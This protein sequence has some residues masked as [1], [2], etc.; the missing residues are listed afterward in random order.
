MHGKQAAPDEASTAI[1]GQPRFV[2]SAAS[3]PIFLPLIVTGPSRILSIERHEHMIRGLKDK[4]VWFSSR[5]NQL[6]TSPVDVPASQLR[7]GDLFVHVA[8]GNRKQ[9]WLWNA[10]RWNPI[11]LHDPHPYLRGYVLNILANGEPSWVT[12]DTI[13]T[14]IS[15]IKKRE[16]ERQRSGKSVAAD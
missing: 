3:D 1:P 9:V 7:H 13:R 4:T 10:D 15:R 5:G 8:T 2:R 6:L 16:R 12:K 14:Y 11:E